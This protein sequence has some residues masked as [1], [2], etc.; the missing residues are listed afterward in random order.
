MSGKLKSHC[1]CG[2]LVY[3]VRYIDIYSL[4]QCWKIAPKINSG[5]PIFLLESCLNPNCF[6]E[7]I[8][9]RCLF[10]LICLCVIFF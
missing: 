7:F 1:I 2:S 5:E 3:V 9:M 10:F 8:F 4:L 6:F